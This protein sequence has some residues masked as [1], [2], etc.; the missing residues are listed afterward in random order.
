MRRDVHET[1]R[2]RWPGILASLGLSDKVLSGK[3]CSCPICGGKDRFRFDNKDG[4]GSYYCNG[5]GAGSGV[6]LYMAVK[7]VDFRTAA[8]EIEILSGNIPASASVTKMDEA[9]KLANLNRVWLEAKPLDG[10]NEA[11]RYLVG[12]GLNLSELRLSELRFHP[13]L[14][15]HEAQQNFPALLSRISDTAGTGLSIHRTYLLNGK[16]APVD[17][18]KK[19]MPGKPLSGGSIQ[20]FQHGN[21]LGIAEGLETAI[22]AQNL[23]KAPVWSCLSSGGIESFKPPVGVKEIEIFADN[24]QNYAGQKSAFVCANRLHREGFMVKVSIPPIEGD[25]LDVLNSQSQMAQGA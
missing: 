5:C 14:Y 9:E 11:R 20:L 13:A 3:H 6:D 1:A 15:H 4:T 12:R 2:N 17:Q 19:I 10:E 22:A 18:P 7:G 21:Y 16:K 24:D 25:W 8:Q 23:F